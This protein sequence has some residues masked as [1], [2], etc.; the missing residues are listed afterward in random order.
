MQVQ[1]AAKYEP[2]IKTNQASRQR[3]S[4]HSSKQPSQIFE[5][6]RNL[7]PHEI[8]RHIPKM[9]GLPQRLTV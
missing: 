7:K 3:I 9:N 2:V 5:V 1:G 6:V 8:Q 4:E